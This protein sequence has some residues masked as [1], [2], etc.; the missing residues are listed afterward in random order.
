MSC[1]F[2]FVNFTSD[3][4]MSCQYAIIS[5]NT[6]KGTIIRWIND[7]QTAVMGCL[8]DPA[9]VQQTSIKCI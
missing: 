1:I 5:T 6:H 2:M 4:F 7:P 8:H 9:N 3:Y